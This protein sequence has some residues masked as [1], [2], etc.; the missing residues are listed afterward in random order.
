MKKHILVIADWLHQKLQRSTLSAIAF[1]QQLLQR[2]GSFSI[3]VV[4]KGATTAASEVAHFGAEAVLIVDTP[5]LSYPLCEHIAP[6]LASIAQTKSFEVVVV[7]STSFGKEIAPRLAAILQA[8]YASDIHAVSLQENKLAYKRALLAGNAYGTCSIE[9]PIHVVSIRQGEFPIAEPIP[10]SSP[11]EFIPLLPSDEA[12]LRT[13]FLSLSS[14]QSRATNLGDAR[15]IVAGGRPLKERF[16]ELLSPLAEALGATLGAT[17][18]PCEGGHAP[19]EL[20]I[21]QTGRSISPLLYLAI[22]I[23]GA[24]QHTAGIKN[25]RVIVAINQDASAPIF[26]I[27]DYGLVADLFVAVPELVNAL[28]AIQNT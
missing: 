19:P 8:G 1:A 27:A 22:G 28:K 7:A 14:E 3:V 23:S 11:I 24:L 9:T 13:E 20:Q 4:G 21:G 5:S 26:N 17:R 18:P 25:A 6:T 2:G 15:I 16:I 10:S 12:A